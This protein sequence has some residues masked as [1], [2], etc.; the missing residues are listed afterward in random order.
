MKKSNLTLGLRVFALVGVI[1]ANWVI[2]ARA[3]DEPCYGCIVGNC[4]EI[5]YGS[6]HLF[7][8]AHENHCDEAFPCTKP[9]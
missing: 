1:A 5:A 4:F 9:L 6:G 8:Q 3:Q 2:P 7:C